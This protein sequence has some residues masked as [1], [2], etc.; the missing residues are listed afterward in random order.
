LIVD[1]GG[2]KVYDQ[3]DSITS[4][5]SEQSRTHH[6]NFIDCIKTRETPTSDI[7]IGHVSST[8]CHLGNISY[9]LGREVV[10]DPHQKNF[11][12]DTQANIMLGRQYRK[13]WELPQG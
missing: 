7:E 3:K 2:W 12:N 8:L 11:G 1:R 5:S 6:Q 10:F 4:D 9:R 13:K